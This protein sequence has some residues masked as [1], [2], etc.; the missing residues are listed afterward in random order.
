MHNKLHPEP[1]QALNIR[2]NWILSSAGMTTEA[3][4]GF[5]RDR[6]EMSIGTLPFR[7]KL[8]SNTGTMG[9]RGNK[10]LFSFLKLGIRENKLKHSFYPV[11]HA[12]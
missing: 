7:V 1:R 2:Y 12:P 3:F 6:Q 4:S 9:I 8:K 10:K 5:L 11:R